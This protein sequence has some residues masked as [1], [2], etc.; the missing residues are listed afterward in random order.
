MWT[1]EFWIQKDL[2][3]WKEEQ[4]QTDRLELLTNMALSQQQGPALLFCFL[5]MWD[6][7]LQGANPHCVCFLCKW[8]QEAV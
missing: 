6:D 3:L 7:L 4:G 5:Y 8:R 2:I 1:N